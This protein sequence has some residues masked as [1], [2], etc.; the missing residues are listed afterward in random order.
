M[1]DIYV[2]LLLTHRRIGKR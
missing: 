2:K 1:L